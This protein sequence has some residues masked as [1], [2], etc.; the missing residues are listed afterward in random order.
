MNFF[1]Y[2]ALRLT[3]RR[4]QCQR[5][6]Q[7]SKYH[8]EGHVEPAE[9]RGNQRAADTADPKAEID[10]PVVFRQVIQPKELA[11]QLREDGNGAAKVKGHAGN[12]CKEGRFIQRG[13]Q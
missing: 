8:A 1:K 4:R 13:E 12:C 5:N 10:N 11:Y 3:N 6:N 7:Q 2:F 9:Q